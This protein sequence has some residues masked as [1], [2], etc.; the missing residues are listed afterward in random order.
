MKFGSNDTVLYF[1][2]PV[3]LKFDGWAGKKVGYVEPGKTTVTE[4]SNLLAA[5]S[6]DALL[7]PNEDGYINVGNDLIVWTT[8]MT[9]FVIY[10]SSRTGGP[11]SSGGGS[12]IRAKTNPTIPDIDEAILDISD[13]VTVT[14]ENGRKIYSVTEKVAEIFSGSNIVNIVKINVG[15]DQAFAVELPWAVLKS[16][17]GYEH[18]VA[19]QAAGERSSVY[20]PLNQ[21]A[22]SLTDESTVKF[23]C[24]VSAGDSSAALLKSWQRTIS[25][26]YSIKVSS[27]TQSGEKT[28]IIKT[29]Q[30]YM[31]LEI[32]L[33]AAG[34]SSQMTGMKENESGTGLSPLPTSFATSG[35]DS[36]ATVYTY[37][38]GNIV[39]VRGERTFTDISDHWAQDSITAMACKALV[40]GK[41]DD[42]FYPDDD[43]IRAEF[44]AIVNRSMGYP[45]STFSG[46]PGVSADDWYAQD[47]AIA[48]A[49][50]LMVVDSSGMRPQDRITRAEI[51]TILQRVDKA[52]NA[53]AEDAA[54][55]VLTGFADNSLIPDWANSSLAWAVQ[56]EIMRGDDDN[57]L[58]AED[59]A[60]RAE[61]LVMITRLMEKQSMFSK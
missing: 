50:G 32:P 60:T 48:A 47:M 9:K 37:V 25:D 12:G 46:L 22:Q 17:Q 53:L 40:N 58:N 27:M 3:R 5:D 21:L 33:A 6:G 41:S 16:L 18:A 11:G 7:A 34:V 56:N 26:V 51:A 35:Q 24:E 38:P 10:E 43:I 36:Y 44:A 61:S 1:D 2:K 31:R 28:E 45:P 15:T 4:I 23:E 8:H 54:T 49:R 19:L 30:D 59:N 52:N 57:S 13:Q 55:D 39:V 20:L 42:A 29:L 14:T